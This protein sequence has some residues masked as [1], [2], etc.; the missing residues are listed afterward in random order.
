MKT[1]TKMSANE[2]L[3]QLFQWRRDKTSLDF[4]E[5]CSTCRYAIRWQDVYLSLHSPEFSGCSGPGTVIKVAIPYCPKC[6]TVPEETG[7]LHIPGL[8]SDLPEL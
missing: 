1:P 6:E 3:R 8:L 4:V 7:C 2:F 5:V